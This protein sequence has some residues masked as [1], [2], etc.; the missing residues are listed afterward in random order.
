VSRNLHRTSRRLFQNLS[1][2]PSTSG[3]AAS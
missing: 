1:V 3:L 2:I